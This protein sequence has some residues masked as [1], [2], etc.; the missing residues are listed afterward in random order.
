M[1]RFMPADFLPS[2]MTTGIGSLP[3]TGPDEAVAFVLECGV[4]APFWPQLPKRCFTEGMVPQFARPVPCVRVVPDE[5][6]IYWEPERKYEELEEFYGLFLG[7]D[8]APFGLGEESAAGFGAFRRA[9]RGRTWPHVKGQVTGP[10]TFTTSIRSADGRVLFGDADLRD[11]AAKVLARNAAWQVEQ[12]ARFAREG[13]I[14]FVDEPVLAVFGSSS[15][16]GVSAELV[17]SMLG[18]VFEAIHAAG[19]ISGMHVCGNSDWGVMASTGVRILNFD[20]YQFGPTVSLYPEAIHALLERGGAIAWGIVPTTP[21][22]ADA[23]LDS[24]ARR[25]EECL[26]ALADKGLDD[27]LLRQ[28]SMLTPSCGAGSMQGA[29]AQKVFDLLLALRELMAG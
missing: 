12:L 14:V 27:A 26:Q 2:L 6:R 7:G 15:L 16:A 18:E 28:R 29:E 9:A 24:L 25:L 17:R 13:V 8:L 10:I 11:A 20:A 4:S 21:D 5:G 19:G 1:G 22:I 23:D 3:H